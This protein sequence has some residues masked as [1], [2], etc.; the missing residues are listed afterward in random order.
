MILSGR[1]L[2]GF[3]GGRAECYQIFVQ[4]L[5]TAVLLVVSKDRYIDMA[6]NLTASAVAKKPEKSKVCYTIVFRSFRC[7]HRR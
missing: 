7:K 5:G 1:S 2:L 6:D 4:S 3:V